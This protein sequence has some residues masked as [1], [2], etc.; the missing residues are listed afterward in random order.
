MAKEGLTP[1][2]TIDK[3]HSDGNNTNSSDTVKWVVTWNRNAN[4]DRLPTEAEWEWTAKGGGKD[5]R[6]TSTAGVRRKR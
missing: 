1:A 6:Y 5:A 4:G 2:Y 3:I